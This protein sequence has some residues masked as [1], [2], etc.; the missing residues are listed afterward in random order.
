MKITDEDR[1]RASYEVQSLA[2]LVRTAEDSAGIDALTDVIAE[3]NAL[4]RARH[5]AFIDGLNELSART[6]VYLHACTTGGCHCSASLDDT[7]HRWTLE[8][9]ALDIE[10]PTLTAGEP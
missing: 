7:P 6:G 10:P 8:D 1:R 2:K 5:A 9:G 3:R 4:R